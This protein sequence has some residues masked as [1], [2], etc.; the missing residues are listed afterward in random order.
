MVTLDDGR[1]L[2]GHPHA[3][4]GRRHQVCD[5]LGLG[6]NLDL[7]LNLRAKKKRIRWVQ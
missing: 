3:V 1:I 6:R 5:G 4:R 7:I 2:N